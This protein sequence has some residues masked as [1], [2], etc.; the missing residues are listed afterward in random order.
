M[1]YRDDLAALSARKAALEQEVS[2][3]TR[4]LAD[5]SQLLDEAA[6]RARLP[7]LD[8]IR[9]AAPCT[10]D[11]D[12]MTGDDRVRHC[13]DCKLDVY[14]LSGMTRGEA[15]ALI[16]SRIGPLCVRFYRRHDDTILT[17]DCPTGVTRRR[18]RR[19]LVASFGGVAASG[20]LAVW[21]TTPDPQQLEVPGGHIVGALDIPTTPPPPPEVPIRLEVSGEAILG[22][23]RMPSPQPE[24]LTGSANIV[25]DDATRTAI[26]NKHVSKVVGTWKLCIDEH[27]A[28]TDAKMLKSTGFPRYDR[29]IRKAVRAWTYSEGAPTCTA[30][31]FVYS[32]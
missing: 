30:I 24:R 1:S 32:P 3:K 21:A 11:W 22:A 6:A 25:P 20:M 13:D 12:A 10:R 8:N 28:V 16:A 29:T 7:I 26:L 23:M 14:N 5:A 18:R 27:G 19:L 2:A 4:E 31:T 17:T 9:V 15:E